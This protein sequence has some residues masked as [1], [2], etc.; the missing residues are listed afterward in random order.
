MRGAL[1]QGIS[2]VRVRTGPGGRRRPGSGSSD[3]ERGPSRRAAS[4]PGSRRP[5]CRPPFRAGRPA[6]PRARRGFSRRCQPSAVGSPR[7]RSLAARRSSPSVV[8]VRVSRAEA[9]VTIRKC[10]GEP[11]AMGSAG[12]GVSQRASTACHCFQVRARGAPGVCR[13]SFP[14]RS[15]PGRTHPWWRGRSTRGR[16]VSRLR[17]A[18]WVAAPGRRRRRWHATPGCGPQAGATAGTACPRRGSCRTALR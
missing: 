6:A 11:V 1:G 9:P 2:R 18:R 14:G 7:C 12:S 17:R 15:A 10:T 5:R 3:P 13:L 8:L 16:A 4:G